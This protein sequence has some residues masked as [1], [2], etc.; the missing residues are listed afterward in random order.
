L[1]F[2]K[3][4]TK[5]DSLSM[6]TSP[7]TK[8]IINHKYNTHVKFRIWQWLILYWLFLFWTTVR[9]VVGTLYPLFWG[10]SK[11]SWP[12]NL[13][14]LPDWINFSAVAT[15]LI[16]SVYIEILKDDLEM[17]TKM[18]QGKW[19]Y[20]SYNSFMLVQNVVFSLQENRTLP[21]VSS[22]GSCCNFQVNRST[23]L[24]PEQKS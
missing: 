9:T 19:S 24:Q 18:K 8:R 10:I 13:I 15:D 20:V 16:T 1:R 11:P 7:P 6:G 21:N 5:S 2:T 12:L 14:V 4:I 23:L 22:S 3:S 17:S